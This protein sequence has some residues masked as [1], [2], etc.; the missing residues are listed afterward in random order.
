[1]TADPLLSLRDLRVRFRGAPGEEAALDDVSLD[2]RAGEVLCLVGAS[3]AGKSVTA[4]TIL[5]LEGH[6]GGI[7]IGG[8]IALGGGGTVLDLARATSAQITAARGRRLGLI[9]QDPSAALNP[10]LT[11][12]AQIREV[13]RLHRGLRGRAAQDA[14]L[15]LLREVGIP[16]PELRLAQFPHELSGGLRQ[17]AMI[18]L[19]LAAQPEV[20]IADEPTTALDVTVQAGILRLIARLCR[21]RGL[22]V[23]FITHDMG[24][25]AR[26][27][28]RVAVMQSG[29]IVEEGRATAIFDEPQ[30]QETR[31]LLQ[32]VRARAEVAPKSAPASAEPCLSVEGL[33]LRYA[34]RGLFR[35]SGPAAVR[36]VSFVLPKGQT[37]ALVGES[38]SGKTSVAR[39]ILQ[40][41]AGYAGRICLEGQALEGL[42]A[43]ALRAARARMQ[44]IFQDPLD[45]L[46]P[47]LTLGVQVAAPLQNYRR[48]TR[49]ARLARVRSLFEKVRLPA[50]LMDRYP[51]EVSG[52][53]RQ[54]VAIARALS[55][56]PALVIADEAVSALDVKVQDSILTLMGDLQRDLSLSY[57][58]I[59][60]DLGV[61]ARL[62]HRV[63]VMQA[64]RIV[65]QGPAVA[66][67]TRPGH[68]YTRALLAAVPRPDPQARAAPVPADVPPPPASG[69]P[70]YDEVAPGHFVLADQTG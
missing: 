54:R 59:S 11:I 27:A 66:V 67:L 34:P 53:Q 29:R 58:F 15:N 50:G 49:Q 64:G 51:H 65:E 12:G 25:V 52:G 62:A 43:S 31:A 8:S 2:L 22:A 33:S 36:D 68:A 48:G 70:R 23:L 7:L 47:R 19:A 60:H 45:S 24:V 56:D 46:D 1:M 3:G 17:R 26:I 30:H 14:L 5:R 10:V 20:L 39:A 69:T 42:G 35:R 40:L 37:L 61:V 13:L 28:D 6:D 16:E 44:M 57:L 21:D 18:A 63:A 4:R 32:A 55:L 41:H 9:F 38:G